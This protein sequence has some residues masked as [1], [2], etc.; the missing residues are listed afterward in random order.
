MTSILF[1]LGLAAIVAGV[2][3]V[4]VPAAVIVG[5]VFLSALAVLSHA[6]TPNRKGGD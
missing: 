2:A 4:Y 3:L 1:V 5:G 6:P